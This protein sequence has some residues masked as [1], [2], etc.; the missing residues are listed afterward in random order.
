MKNLMILAICGLA[1]ISVAG[2]N[3]KID[4]GSLEPD[5]QT[6]GEGKTNQSCDP[7][8][9]SGPLGDGEKRYKQQGDWMDYTIYFENKTN[10]TAAAQEV[11]V[12]LPMDENLDWSTLE[13]GEI[14]FGEHID[15]SFV[16][17][18]LAGKSK[19]TSSYAMPGTN[20]SVKTEVKMKDGVLSWY[21]R[22]WDPTTADNFPA[23]A[24]GG[25][26]PPNDPET[27]CGEGHL[28]F[29]VRVKSDAPNGAVIRA[30]AQIVFDNN[31]MIETDPSWWNTVAGLVDVKMVVDGVETNLSLIVGMPYGELP[32]PKARTG[33]T[34]TGWFT[35]PNGTGRRV[36]ADSLVEAG[37]KG[38]YAFWTINKYKLTLVTNSTS[39]GMV[40]GG[41]TY[42]YGATATLKAAAKKGY[43]FAGWFTDKACTK[44]LTPKGYDN[45]NPTVKIVVSAKNTTIY[46]KFVT[47][48]EA[49]KALKF[50]SATKK[51]VKTAK[52]ATAG[53]AFSLK[54]GITSVSLPTVTAKGLP[55]GLKIDK[56]TGEITGTPTKPGSFT[57]TVTVKD[58]AGNTITQ[59]V[60]ITVEAAAYA[61]G[62]FYGTAKP[63]K[64]S[65]PAAYLQFTVG[66]T[67]KVSGKVTYKGKAYSFKSTLASCTA[68]KATFAPKVKIGKTTFK[69][70]TVT[71]KT[72]K[73]GGLSLVEAANSKRTF[74]AQK[75]PGLVKKGK[76]LAKLVGKSFTFTKKTKNSGLTKSGDKLKVKLADGD[77]VTASGTVNG[78]KL[79]ALSAPLI[80]SE[81]SALDG[82]TTYTLY[83]DILDAKIKYYKTVVFTVKVP[84]VLKPVPK[85]SAAFAK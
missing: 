51:L 25:F 83:A 2:T 44:P 63:G 80:V 49:K 28:S 79:A 68:S 24:T 13:L 45:R 29:R 41:G 59:K 42:A 34:F 46:A 27:H 43:V 18:K 71:V 22:D 55:K 21:M 52:K 33:Y 50:S 37:D 11:F 61:K 56:T 82:M 57:A 31:P 39:R 4:C 76:A 6:R 75:K 67:G 15:T 66:K 1:A 53:K 17:K 62:T 16:E 64:K 14:A 58:A 12:D 32:T 9:I 81:V 77:K 30:S 84:V 74:A 85:V 60:K 40:S 78:K 19:L 23:S 54:L 35:G 5:G 38:L 70:G 48:A 3:E 69:P 10:A 65:D 26:L 73:I 72:R 7:N 47:A 36:T 8:E 20:T